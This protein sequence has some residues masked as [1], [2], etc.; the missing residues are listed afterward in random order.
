MSTE[1]RY[2]HQAMRKLEEE[3]NQKLFAKN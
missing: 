1:I 3:L 2:M